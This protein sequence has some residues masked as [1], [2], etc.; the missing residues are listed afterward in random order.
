[1]YIVVRRRFSDKT[2]VDSYG[3]I[4]KWQCRVGEQKRD[5]KCSTESSQTAR[6]RDRATQST[7]QSRRSR[8][9]SIPSCNWQEADRPFGQ[10]RSLVNETAADKRSRVQMYRCPRYVFLFS[11]ECISGVKTPRLARPFQFS[12]LVREGN[13]VNGR[14]GRNCATRA[15]PTWTFPLCRRNS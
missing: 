2:N 14:A 15:S 13:C 5:V 12:L 9:G 4:V 6:D 8:L 11:G 3:G 10:R 1:M 7:S